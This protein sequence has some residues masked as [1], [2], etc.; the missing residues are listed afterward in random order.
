[1]AING[2]DLFQRPGWLGVMLRGDPV[3]YGYLLGVKAGYSQGK[4]DQQRRSR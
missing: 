4:A 2:G 1:M 3:F